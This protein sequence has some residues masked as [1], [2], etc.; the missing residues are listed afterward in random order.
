MRRTILKIEK[1]DDEPLEIEVNGRRLT[2][3]IER[4]VFYVAV[5]LLVSG[6]L[7]L[8]VVVVLPLL[9]IAL[10]VVFAIIGVGIV[11]VAIGLVLVLLWRVVSAFLEGST[12]RGRRRDE[13]D[14]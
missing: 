6:A 1:E 3:D 4:G 10:G 9:G 7:W 11:V 5:V 2:G 12:E 14:E 8:T 13:W